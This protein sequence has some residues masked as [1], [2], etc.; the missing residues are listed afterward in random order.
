MTKCLC[1]MLRP[2]VIFGKE[3][4]V[5]LQCSCSDDASFITGIIL[6]ESLWTP[7]EAF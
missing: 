2:I 3:L 5:E 4:I 1:T 7:H 6:I